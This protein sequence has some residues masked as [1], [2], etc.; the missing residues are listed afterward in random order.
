MSNLSLL[1]RIL[2][3]AL[4]VSVQALYVPASAETAASSLEGTIVS[5]TD[6]APLGGVKL[7]AGDPKTGHIFSSQTTGDDGSFAVEG[8]PAA[9]YELA[10]EA[11]GGLYMIR[12]P[13]QLA[14]G[15]KQNLT[16]AVNR[17][18]DDEEDDDEAGAIPGGGKIH[19][20]TI[21]DNPGTAAGLVI[22]L[23]FL[24][25]ALI[26]DATDDPEGRRSPSS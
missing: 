17:K 25:G 10:V 18:G 19:K 22:G 15:Q 26:E 3:A 23:A 6:H 7:H 8:L 12:T 5:A 16:V 24:I 2:A 11:D 14:P 20:A 1:P 21:W 4:I 13:V 9:A